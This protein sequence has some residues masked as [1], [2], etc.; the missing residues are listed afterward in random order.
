MS[1]YVHMG[2]RE[3]NVADYT[4]TAQFFA[5]FKCPPE[6]EGEGDQILAHHAEWVARTHPREGDNALL[7]YT[8]TKGTDEYGNI[9]FLLYEVYA[10]MAGVENHTRIALDDEEDSRVR[11]LIAWADKCDGSIRGATG[12]VLHSLW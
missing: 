9:V 12:E 7:Q 4:G 11:D 5:A 2:E 1:P 10:T 8:V 6:H 3:S